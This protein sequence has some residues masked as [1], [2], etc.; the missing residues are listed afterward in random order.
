[1]HFRKII[2]LFLALFA[3]Q[4]M[5]ATT[6]MAQAGTVVSEGQDYLSAPDD[7]AGFFD[8]VWVYINYMFYVFYI[9]GIVFIGIAWIKFNQR[10]YAAVAWSIGG[11]IGLFLTPRIVSMIRK[12]AMDD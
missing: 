10:D 7:E 8:R 11:A 12:V 3:F 6:A 2:Y 9:L 5:F 1:M 4:G